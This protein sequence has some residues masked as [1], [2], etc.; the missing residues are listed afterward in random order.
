MANIPAEL[1]YIASHEWIRDEGNG[2]YTV[3]ITDFA[4][5]ALGDIVFVELPEVG[6][7]VNRD[8]AIAV[9]ESV[10]AASDIYSPLSGEIVEINEMLADEPE[11]ANEEPYEAAWFFKIK[12]SEE[13]E[14]ESLLSAEQY[15]GECD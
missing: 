3:G 1:K 13:G 4:Q 7:E 11:K 8:D 14:I 9:V 15:E 2:I 12:I 6:A 10:K 5:A